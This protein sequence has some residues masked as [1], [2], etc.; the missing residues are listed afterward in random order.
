MLLRALVLT[1][2]CALT[3]GCYAIQAASGQWEVMRRSRPIEQVLANPA[4]PAATRRGLELTVAARSFAETELGLP[5]SRSYRKYADLGRP[6]VVWNVVA[7]PEFSVEPRRWCFPVAGCVAYRGYFEESAARA[8]ALRLSIRGDDVSLGGVPTYST[9]GHLPDPVF[10]SMLGWRDTRLVGTIF[11]ELAH[12]QLYVPDDSEFNEAFAS[13]VEEE[14]LRR[15]LAALGRA[16]ELARFATESQRE[17]EFAR[18]LRETRRRLERLYASALP[19]E[20]MRV[21]KQREFGRLKFLYEQAREK[22]GWGGSYDAFFRRA[23]NNAHLAAV[24]TYRDCMPG[25]RHELE[26]L[27]SMRAF[28]ERAKALAKLPARERRDAVCMN[29]DTPNFVRNGDTPN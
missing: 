27:G 3:S 2:L 5:D 23:V 21:E 28:Y 24:A 13:V 18:L 14:G 17:A 25:L 4:T 12:E 15:W 11:H 10:A 8:Q 26:R 16:D 29:G 1:L 20:Q 6:Y 19:D 9:L 22:W 7:T